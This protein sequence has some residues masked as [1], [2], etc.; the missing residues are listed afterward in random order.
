MAIAFAGHSEST[1]SLL[2][3]MEKPGVVRSGFLWMQMRNIRNRIVHHY[4]PE[5]VAEMFD[6]LTRVFAP[7]PLRLAE[8]RESERGG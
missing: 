4:L 7:E 3:C 1:R 2:D 5:L 8:R 6:L